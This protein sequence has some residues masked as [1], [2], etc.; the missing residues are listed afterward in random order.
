MQANTLAIESALARCIGQAAIREPRLQAAIQYAVLSGGKRIRPLLTLACAELVGVAAE[1]ALPAAVAIE[2]VHC[3]SLVHDDLPCMDNDALRRGQP[4][5]H[6]Q[7]GEAT[8]L[9]A[10]DYLPTLAMLQL[11]TQTAGSDIIQAQCHILS[12]ACC[13]M[14]DGQALD[15]AAEQTNDLSLTQ[16]AELH[17]LKTGK[18]LQ[19]AMALGYQYAKP[20]SAAQTALTSLGQALG[21]AYQIQD[22]ILDLTQDTNTLGKTAQAD[23]ARDKS[24]YPKLLGLAGAKHALAEQQQHITQALQ[25]LTALG[26]ATQ[27]L[28][29]VI[30]YILQRNH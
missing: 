15:L 16:L 6:I 28:S 10:G 3:Y 25:Q 19:A 12:S 21:L 18:L 1:R 11:C 24:T 20:T 13:A 14:V 8:A 9:L 23:L 2:L 27:C 26:L 29:E 30:S 7:F 22:D 17:S 4:T 5:C